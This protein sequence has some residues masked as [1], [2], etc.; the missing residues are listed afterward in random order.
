MLVTVN[1]QAIHSHPAIKQDAQVVNLQWLQLKLWFESVFWF[2]LLISRDF[3][4]I[5]IENIDKTSKNKNPNQVET[6]S[7]ITVPNKDAQ[8]G[9]QIIHQISPLVDSSPTNNINSVYLG[10]NA[11]N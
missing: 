6:A 5:S 4:Y 8:I 1:M 11:A 3:L 2:L 7:V 9:E 10:K